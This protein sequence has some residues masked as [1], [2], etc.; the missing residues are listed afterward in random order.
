HHH[1][2]HP[3]HQHLI[4]LLLLL[5]LPLISLIS[6]IFLIFLIF[7]TSHLPFLFLFFL[8]HL[9]FSHLIYPSF[10]T[11]ILFT[12]HTVHIIQT[13]W[14]VRFHISSLSLFL[15][16]YFRFTSV[17]SSSFLHSF[18]ISSV[19]RFSQRFRPKSINILRS[20][21]YRHLFIYL[22]ILLAAF[23]DHLTSS[24]L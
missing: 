2:A 11:F 12:V 10:H 21:N 17:S 9:S 14:C 3:H 20:Y 5:L 18:P 13:I 19:K 16:W 4:F 1:P 6:L 15:S 24:L 7:L 22:V 23:S 8:F